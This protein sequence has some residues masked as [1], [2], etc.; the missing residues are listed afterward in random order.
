MRHRALDDKPLAHDDVADDDR[1]PPA[2][3][4]CYDA[5]ESLK[6]EGG[7]FQ[8]RPNQYQLER[9]EPDYGYLVDH[10]DPKDEGEQERRSEGEND[11][12]S[13]RVHPRRRKMAGTGGRA[14]RF[15]TAIPTKVQ[16]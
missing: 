8:N 14:T 4:V 5:R 1:Q 10:V 6:D 7:R 9:A 12:N 11:V 2:L 16:R 13:E 15:R 3:H